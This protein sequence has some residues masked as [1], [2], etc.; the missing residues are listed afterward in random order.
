MKDFVHNDCRPK[1]NQHF[2][3]NHEAFIIVSAQSQVVAG[4]N[5]LFVL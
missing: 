2:G 3:T 5:Y 1:I 4:T